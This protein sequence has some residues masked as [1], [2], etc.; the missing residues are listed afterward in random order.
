MLWFR[1]PAGKGHGLS[2]ILDAEQ[3]LYFFS[4][5]KLQ[6]SAGFVVAIHDQSD[7]AV[8]DSKGVSVAPGTDARIGLARKQVQPPRL[9]QVVPSHSVAGSDWLRS[10]SAPLWLKTLL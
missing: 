1:P 10:D 5:K 7:V 9:G 4:A 8:V 3:S 6:A 2:I